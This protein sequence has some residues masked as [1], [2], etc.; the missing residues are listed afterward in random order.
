MMM[1]VFNTKYAKHPKHLN[2][3]LFVFSFRA[4]LVEWSKGSSILRQ[5]QNHHER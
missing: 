4:E 5:A 1:R 2:K 3:S